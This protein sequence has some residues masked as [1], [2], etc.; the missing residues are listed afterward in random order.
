MKAII[1]FL[2]LI[3]FLACNSKINTTYE[4]KIKELRDSISIQTDSIEIL[5]NELLDNK[6]ELGRYEYILNE[7]ET[8]PYCKNKIK[9]MPVE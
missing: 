4:T 2:V 9:N 3:F 6:I 1:L 7:L 8:D 5:N